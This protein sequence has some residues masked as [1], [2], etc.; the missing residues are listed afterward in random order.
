LSRTRRIIR[1]FVPLAIAASIPISIIWVMG[2]LINNSASFQRELQMTNSLL[3]APPLGYG[4]AEPVLVGLETS[5]QTLH[6]YDFPNQQDTSQDQSNWGETVRNNIA[7]ADAKIY[8][9]IRID[10]GDA[11]ASFTSEPEEWSWLVE[12][13]RADRELRLYCKTPAFAATDSVTS[14]LA[15]LPW[16]G[17]LSGEYTASDTTILADASA[18]ADATLYTGFSSFFGPSNEFMAGLAQ[19]NSNDGSQRWID[20]RAVTGEAPGVVRNLLFLLTMQFRPDAIFTHLSEDKHEYAWTMNTITPDVRNWY[21][22]LRGKADVRPVANIV[23]DSPYL[24]VDSALMHYQRHFIATLFSG[25]GLAGHDIEITKGSPSASADL[26]II[27]SEHAALSE[28]LRS[29]VNGDSPVL[30]FPV[31]GLVTTG[32]MNENTAPFGLNADELDA[33]TTLTAAPDRVEA[34]GESV[35]WHTENRQ[36]R[37]PSFYPGLSDAEDSNNGLNAPESAVVKR[38]GNKAVF[39]GVA[40]HPEAAFVIARTAAAITGRRTTLEVPFNGYGVSGTRSAFFATHA[41]NLSAHLHHDNGEPFEEG[42][43]IRTAR[44]NHYGNLKEQTELD[45]EA[46]FT[47]AMMAHELIIV[48]AIPI[49]TR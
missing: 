35:R 31:R 24:A 34:N 32:S 38:E 14:A 22:Y 30:W 13:L 16:D 28:T 3:D 11:T 37:F 6:S 5:L 17:V 42:T 49:Q 9:A 48:E 19:R 4:S 12:A 41:A 8:K 23:F 15:T 29:L 36:D 39:N 1:T 47:A 7:W 43:R 44:F 25:L 27:L 33:D 2:P 10:L 45:Y 21:T 20:G 40:L 26:H 18:K 46:P